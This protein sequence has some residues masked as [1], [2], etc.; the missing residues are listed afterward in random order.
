METKNHLLRG[1]SEK[2]LHDVHIHSHEQLPVSE[3]LKIFR[4]V[5]EHFNYDKI[6]LNVIFSKHGLAENEKGFYFK[7]NI[8]GV[9]L[10]A[11]PIHRYD[12][13][14]TAEGYLEQIKTYYAMGCDG[15]KILDGKP[16]QRL[17]LGKRLDDAIFDKFYGYAEENG[18]PVLMHLGDPPQWW[19]E[20]TCPQAAKDLGWY[21][22][23]P[24][25]TPFEDTVNEVEGI[26][27]KFPGLKL[28][29]AHFFFMGD[30]LPYLEEFFGKW[31]NTTVDL[32]PGGEMFRHFSLNYDNARKFFETYADRILYGTD[33]YNWEQ[34]TPTVEERYAHS[35]NLVRTYLEKNEEF[36]HNQATWVSEAPLKPFAF[37]GE[38]LDKIYRDNFTRIWG[39][40]PR[41]LDFELIAHQC[42]KCMETE[43]LTEL[44]TKNIQEALQFF[45][46]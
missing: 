10:N 26:L 23:D 8:P 28:T 37:E 24:K 19:H 17:K 16:E 25:Y 4:N 34:T 9:Y 43:T 42:K 46:K 7:A 21:Y 2:P 38:I 20:D 1:Y 22:A 36:N 13:R 15:I 18:I 14:D 27:T 11:G 44:D 40:N 32:T 5:M 30:N 39:E 41:P 6:L 29:L 45:Q 33:I 3:S 31:K 35:V 12:E